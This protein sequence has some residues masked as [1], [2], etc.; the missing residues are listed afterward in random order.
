[1]NNTFQ[2]FPRPGQGIVVLFVEGL[3]WDRIP[4]EDLTEWMK[5]LRAE[6]YVESPGHVKLSSWV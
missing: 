3:G 6:G 1:M 4:E 5:L 2:I